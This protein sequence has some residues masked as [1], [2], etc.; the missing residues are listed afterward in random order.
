MVL[1]SKTAI[2][3][4]SFYEGIQP[5]IRESENTRENEINLKSSLQR[6]IRRSMHHSCCGYTTDRSPQSAV[7]SSVWE[8]AL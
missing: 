5:V 3:L 6:K 4:H 8:T 7:T 1:I 2:T